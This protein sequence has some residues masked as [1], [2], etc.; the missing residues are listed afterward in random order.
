[1]ADIALWIATHGIAAAPKLRACILLAGYI[2]LA[3]QTGTCDAA[4]VSIFTA[5][6]T[7]NS[8]ALCRLANRNTGGSI[9]CAEAAAAFPAAIAQ[10][11]MD[12]TATGGARLG[13]TARAKRGAVG[14]RADPGTTVGIFAAYIAAL[15]AE[16]SA[17]LAQAP[18]AQIGTAIAALRAGIAGR[19]TGSRQRRALVRIA[20]A[21]AAFRCCLAGL[22][23][24]NTGVGATSTTRT[25]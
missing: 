23:V 2:S 11:A 24:L 13:R 22:P 10:L 5:Q 18:I 7:V 15:D 25:A 19:L 6:F 4:A 1:V 14:D 21:A 8:A 16:G 17:D 20:A 12:F 9:R 3:R